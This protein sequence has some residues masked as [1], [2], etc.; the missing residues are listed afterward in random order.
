[1]LDSAT[2]SIR[3]FS[4]EFFKNMVDQ[5]NADESLAKLTKGMNTSLLLSCNELSLFYLI[6]IKEGRLAVKQASSDQVAEFAFSAPYSEWEKIAR[7]QAKIPSEVISGRIRFKGSMPK[8]LLYL[9]KVLGL[10]GKIMKAISSM[11]LIFNP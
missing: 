11:N 9:N 10:E 3:F 1:M 4:F 8:M 7:N 5:L 2:Q 6:E